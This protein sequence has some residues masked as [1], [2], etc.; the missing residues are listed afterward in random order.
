MLQDKKWERELKDAK[1]G[2]VSGTYQWQEEAVQVFYYSL[3]SIG[4][5]VFA[6]I[7]FESWKKKIFQTLKEIRQH[8]GGIF[9]P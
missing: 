8:G 3:R 1:A 2:G 7:D 9:L 4:H 6:S 5:Y